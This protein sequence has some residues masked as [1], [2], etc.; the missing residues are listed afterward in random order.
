[1]G[2]LGAILIGSAWAGDTILEFG[3]AAQ[4]PAGEIEIIHSESAP[5]RAE[6][7]LDESCNCYR[8][9]AT[10]DGVSG[11]F[12]I[13]TGASLVVVSKTFADRAKVAPTGRTVPVV[14]GGGT[15]Q[16]TLGKVKTIS[17]QGV[18]VGDVDVVVLKDISGYDGVVGMNVLSRLE[19]TQRD[20][21]I[22]LEQPREQ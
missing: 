6:Y 12:M 7:T 3:D 21:R 9:P 19:M 2:I 10:L 1:M 15:V 13:D 16:G 18:T 22:T 8:G 14:T 20:G 4:R 11:T 17:F 5:P